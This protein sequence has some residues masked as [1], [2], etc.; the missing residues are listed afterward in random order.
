[1]L[2]V[3]AVLRKCDERCSQN[4]LFQKDLLQVMF[5]IMITSVSNEYVKSNENNNVN[6][7]MAAR[8]L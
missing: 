8:F 4:T 2:Y 3:I 1:V 5:T 6:N 7:G